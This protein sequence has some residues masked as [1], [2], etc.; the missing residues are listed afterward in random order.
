MKLQGGE[1]IAI[2]RLESIYKSCTYISNIC[3]HATTEAKQPIAI[4]IPHEGHLR[5]GLESVS[6]VDEKADFATL[7]SHAK[8]QELVL[9]DCNAAG[10]KNGFKPM[11]LLQGV[12]L[13]ADE[14]TPESGLVTAA[15]KLQRKKVAEKY[16][17]EIKVRGRL[18][19]LFSNVG[20]LIALLGG[21]QGQGLI[22]ADNACWFRVRLLY[23]V[24]LFAITLRPIFHHR[25]FCISLLGFMTRRCTLDRGSAQRHAVEGCSC[26]DVYCP[27]NVPLLVR[28]FPVCFF[29]LL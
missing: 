2:E 8:V 29:P 15:Q 10:K 18:S 13:T 20:L 27:S 16:D 28:V 4:I 23:D 7:C 12:I 25:Q 5:Q 3:V 9:K 1:Y 11:E 21:V 24:L 26:V 14:W 6:G 19:A 17:R 22:E